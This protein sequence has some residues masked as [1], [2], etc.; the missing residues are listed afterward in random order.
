MMAI[1]A[2][3]AMKA[4]KSLHFIE[5]AFLRHSI[6]MQLITEAYPWVWIINLHYSSIRQGKTTWTK[7]SL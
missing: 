7:T 2:N 4:A 1:W 5:C 6:A 3:N